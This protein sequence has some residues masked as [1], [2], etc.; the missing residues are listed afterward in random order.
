MS[1]PIH[2]HGV[3]ERKDP[4]LPRF[5]VIPADTLDAWEP[6]GTFIAEVTLDGTAIGR[7]SVKAWGGGRDVWLFDLTREQ[8]RR[9]AVDTGD[10][11]RIELRRA[12]T[13]PPVELRELL[14]ADAAART[15]WS[16]LS[17]A[18]R[19]RIAEHVRQ[20]KRPETRRARARRA[21]EG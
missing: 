12:D 3:V 11:V 2:L 6:T 16:E 20:A 15:T 7:R 10:R 21:F 8:C 1:R 13:T 19:R 18:H 14:E 4:S 17:A 9:A 5:V